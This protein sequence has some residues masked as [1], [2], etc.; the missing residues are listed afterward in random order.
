[1]LD[2]VGA[3][4]PRLSA[5][6]VLFVGDTPEMDVAG[7]ARAGMR[8]A[9]IGDGRNGDPRPDVCVSGA[10]DLPRHLPSRAPGS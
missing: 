8:T 7:P 4:R 6:H 3:R 9:L 1:V 2:E 10:A 5:E